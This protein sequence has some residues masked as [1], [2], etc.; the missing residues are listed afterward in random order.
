[1]NIDFFILV[2]IYLAIILGIHY[3]LKITKISTIKSII[4]ND[5]VQ[6]SD[7]IRHR[8]QDMVVDEDH[9]FIL[10]DENDYISDTD[11]E[12]DKSNKIVN[13]PPDSDLIINT[14]E[15]NNMNDSISNDF[16]KYLSVGESN[17]VYRKSDDIEDVN[18]T[19]NVDVNLTDNADVDL[20]DN[21]DVNLTD[22]DDINI[23]NSVNNLDTF[24]PEKEKYT[25]EE[26]SVKLIKKPCEDTLSKQYGGLLS[27][28]NKLNNDQASNQV[29]A[30]DEFN[31]SYALI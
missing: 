14:D 11:S 6:D 18:L 22:T 16:M 20:T 28:E 23:A 17:K 24:F 29:R 30:F 26:D 25:F 5:K 13:K 21:V 9:D 4:S 27:D 3:K 1:M 12:L 19:D 7:F 10:N 8:K 2:I 15:L 31:D